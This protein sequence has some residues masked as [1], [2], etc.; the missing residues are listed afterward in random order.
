MSFQQV[1]P[2]SAETT[3]QCI[4][5]RPA[6]WSG[7]IVEL[8]PEGQV[9]C[10]MILCLVRTGIGPFL[11]SSLNEAFSLSVCLRSVGLCTRMIHPE[12][13]AGLANGLDV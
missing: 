11:Q 2:V 13:F 8:H 9:F 4:I 5:L 6:V 1:V 3:D 7:P 12:I 10:T